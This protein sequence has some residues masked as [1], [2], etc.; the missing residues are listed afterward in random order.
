MAFNIKLLSLN[1]RGLRNRMKRRQ[2]FHWL[3]TIHDGSNCYVFLQE[4]HS[5]SDD[6][7][8]WQTDWESKIIF[9]HGSSK[10][11]GVAILF[12]MSCKDEK[13]DIISSNNNGRKIGVEIFS[14]NELESMVLLNVY[15]P[16]KDKVNEQIKFINQLRNELDIY[17]DKVIIG[18]DFNLYLDPLLDK[19]NSR[20]QNQSLNNSK[21][22]TNLLDDYSYIDIWRI[23]NPSKKRFTW[24]RNRPI[25]QSRLDY[26]FI[27]NEKIYNVNTTSI[28]PSIKTDHSL[29]TL[30]LKSSTGDQRGPG[31]W[32]FNVV[33][34]Q[35]NEYN[36]AIRQ[37][38][39]DD[40][41]INNPSL[42]W[43]FIKMKI[44]EYS[45]KFSKEIARKRRKDEAILTEKVN[46]FSQIIDIDPSQENIEQL[47]QAIYNLDLVNTIKT[48][49]NMI[50][51]RAQWVEFG[52][53]NSKYFLNLEKRNYKTK[54][55][56]KLKVNQS[57]YTENPR[58]IL[59][60]QKEFYENLYSSNERSDYFDD[61]FLNN[62]PKLSKANA[63]LT[64]KP[65]SP[66]EITIALKKMKL[67]KTPGTDGLSVDFYIFFWN[68]LKD[69]VYNSIRD[70]FET[71]KMSEEQRRAV[72]RLIP[73]KD[74]DI[75]DLKNWRPISLLNTD[76][77]I[78]AQTLSARLQ[79][80]LDEI[81]S[82]DQNGYLEGRFIGLNIRTILD[83]IQHSNEGNLNTIIA[84]L[85]FEKAFDKLNWNF[86]QKTLQQFGFGPHFRKWIH[87]MYNDISSCVINN[88]YT[89]QYFKLK[90]GIRQGCPLSALLFIIAAETLATA[91]K[92]N[93]NIKGVYLASSHIKL[94]Q[95]ADDTT[96]FVKDIRS[97]HFALNLLHMFHKSS[98]LRLNYS[99]TEILC[100][101]HIY[102]NKENPFNLKW[103]KERVYALGTWFYKDIYSCTNVNYE[104]RF[105]M[106]QSTLKAWKARHLTWFGKITILKA[107]ALPKLNYCISTLPTP[108][109]FAVKVQNEINKFL[110]NEKPPRIKFKNAISKP[111][112]GGLKLTHMDTFIKAQKVVWV[113]RL[114]DD[115]SPSFNYLKQFLPKMLFSDL[116]YCS[117]SPEDMSCDIPL[118]YRQVLYVWFHIQ[119]IRKKNSQN[120]PDEIIWLNKC[121]Q[122]ENKYI[123][124]EKWYLKG[125]VRIKDLTQN[126]KFLSYEEFADKYDLRC[127]PLEY[128]GVVNAI[129]DNWRRM[130][131]QNKDPEAVK[132]KCIEVKS[133]AIYWELIE[134]IQEQASCICSWKTNY[135]VAFPEKYWTRIFSLVYILTKHVKM[136]EFQLKIIHKIYAT[137]SYVNNFDKTVKKLCCHCNTKN[138]IIHWF[139]ECSKL[140]QFWKLF[141]NWITGNFGLNFKFDKNV[142]LFG[143][144]DQPAF[145][146]NYCILFAKW[147]IHKARKLSAKT[148]HLYFSFTSFLDSL[149]Q[150]VVIEKQIALS[151]K[152]VH[153]FNEKFCILESVL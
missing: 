60:M 108:E 52:E 144:I 5:S 123:F 11:C 110:W 118:F 57:D 138:N 25:V 36:T 38:I 84:F 139:A 14:E 100:I 127:N 135:D 131:K 66:E 3:K 74:K 6:E 2:I 152:T 62:L 70:A 91:I 47:E 37:I 133:K 130:I 42:K 95:L 63:E 111:E 31:L 86:M 146:L 29:I 72:L 15:S 96:L 51:S 82:K 128:Y 136:R 109:W 129:P 22:M 53:K 105:A 12:P 26:W 137:D 46:R 32:K 43:E 9:D 55:I 64:E 147:Y 24:R 150:S 141:S 23:K 79:K 58:E 49:G 20:S 81:I 50:R 78:L 99:K 88:G 151:N 34:L 87:V 92:A 83:V 107:L 13:Y 149:K 75:T 101:G 61:F 143:Y 69:I 35:N 19:D 67:G 116:L 140:K 18:G 115:K 153:N 54:H 7:S 56:T 59:K 21:E 148:D 121:I 4:T 65:L 106:F 113:K 71:N 41:T 134:T 119:R 77:K 125:V 68:D 98:G 90:C 30:S 132:R 93:V 33:L 39:N 80:V 44:R 17:N 117:I 10:S 94:S 16:T 114:L 122:I 8:E 89:S 76:Y 27:P 142:I 97:L 126:N 124:Y 73:K 145:E 120:V 102:S 45:I 85:D 28:E 112:C 40:Y 104:N 103:V 1:V 48:N